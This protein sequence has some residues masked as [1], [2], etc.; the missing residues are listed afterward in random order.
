MYVGQKEPGM[1]LVLIFLVAG[2]APKD[3]PEIRRED[4]EDLAPADRAGDDREHR[5]GKSERDEG[6]EKR[7]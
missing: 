6:S 4:G 5:E 3:A 1:N 2:F 7:E